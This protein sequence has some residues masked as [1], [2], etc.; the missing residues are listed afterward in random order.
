MLPK[1]LWRN[2]C[3][4]SVLYYKM[5]TTFIILLQSNIGR[6]QPKVADFESIPI[7]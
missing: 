5:R 6:R 3:S 2:M 7:G 1:M 4:V